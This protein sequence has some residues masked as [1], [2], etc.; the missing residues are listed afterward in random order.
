MR[1]LKNLGVVYFLMLHVLLVI[2]LLKSDFIDNAKYKFGL[3]STPELSAYYDQITT[4]HFSIDRNVPEGASIFIGDSITQGLATSAIA[5]S[6]VNY[7]IGRDTTLGVLNR[8]TRYESLSRAGSV[9]IAIGVNDLH[10]RGD[11]EIVSNYADI[12]NSLP[13]NI[14]VVVSAILPVDER[15]EDISS[16]NK[17]ILK[18]NDSI[19]ELVSQHENVTFSDAGE[20]LR[21]ADNNLKS[22]YHTGDGIHLNSE[23]YQIWIRELKLALN[24]T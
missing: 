7:G 15:V 18:V 6:S 2:V 13:K 19:R 12:L 24:K 21:G 3:S 20:D 1:I 14:P 22:D 23:G 10:R 17:R 11:R 16:K 4:F 8:I 9:V 5:D